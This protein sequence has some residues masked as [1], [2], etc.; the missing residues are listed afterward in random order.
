[1]DGDKNGN[2]T[3]L[4]FDELQEIG[5]WERAINS[6]RVDL[7]CDIYITGSNAYLPSSELAT[8]LSGCHVEIEILPLT[9]SEYL[10]FQGATLSPRA[11]AGVEIFELLDGSLASVGG[12]LDQFRRCGGL[13][14]SR[15]VSQTRRPTGR[16]ADPST[17]RPSCATSSNETA[18]VGA[19]TSRVPTFSS[20]RVIS[21][22]ITG[23]IAGRKSVAAWI[24]RWSAMQ[25][26]AAAIDP[27]RES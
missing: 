11:A 3:Y 4:F 8:L 27:R 23:R 21:L 16:T 5:G 6:L 25:T 18:G 2:H 14:T 7:D 10:D 15:S 20:G 22:P 26:F 1:M 19:G 9:F 13:S 17:R 24:P 12:L